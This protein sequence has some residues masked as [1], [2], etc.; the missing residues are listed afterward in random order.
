VLYTDFTELVYAG[1]RQRAQLMVLL[2]HATKLAPG[3]AVAKTATTRLALAAWTRAEA[4]LRRRGRSWQGSIIHYDQD[5]VYTSYA[6]MRQVLVVDK[7]RLSYA[8]Q[9]AR[10][11]PHMQSFYGRVKVENRSLLLDPENREELVAVVRKRIRYYTRVRRHSSL[12]MISPLESGALSTVNS[13]LSELST[14]KQARQT[15]DVHPS[16]TSRPRRPRLS[17]CQEPGSC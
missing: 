16:T 7:A 1:E 8:L 15:R 14:C 4:G 3:W 5:S 11:N 9:G 12:G 6:W 10:D 13:S 17:A 2:D